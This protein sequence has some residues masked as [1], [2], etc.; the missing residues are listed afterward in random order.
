MDGCCLLRKYI[1]T[2][3]LWY[4]YNMGWSRHVKENKHQRN[5]YF[6]DLLTTLLVNT[7]TDVKSVLKG[8]AV[9]GWD[10]TREQSS[11]HY[12]TSRGIHAKNWTIQTETPHFYTFCHKYVSVL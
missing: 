3:L 8:L 10:D 4:T 11:K 1:L 2:I 6:Y 12:T 7:N 9:C 5:I